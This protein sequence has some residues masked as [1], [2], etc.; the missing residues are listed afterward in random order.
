MVSVLDD[1]FPLTPIFFDHGIDVIA[2]LCVK[3][4]PKSHQRPE[5]F[6]DLALGFRG[7]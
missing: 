7:L 5:L 4:V 2:G 6:L 3:S 1:T